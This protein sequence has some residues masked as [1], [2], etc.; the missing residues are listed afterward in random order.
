MN[1]RRRHISFASLADLA[2]SLLSPEEQAAVL[3]HLAACSRC[4]DDYA[5][6]QRTTALMR[7]DRGEDAP[8]TLIERTIGLFQPG[9]APAVPALRER[10]IAM[11][12]FDSGAA[13]LAIGLRAERPGERQRLFEAG[14]YELD[15]RTT[16]T[17]TGWVLSGQVLGPCAGGRAELFGGERSPRATLNELCEFAFEPVVAGAYGLVLSLAE[18]NTDIEVPEL[19]LGS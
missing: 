10:L 3:A 4:Q 1:I 11:L 13:P 15:L 14:E 17:E 12:R 16:R 9:Q 7:S 8:E 19:D 18:S 2:E 5:W 6:L